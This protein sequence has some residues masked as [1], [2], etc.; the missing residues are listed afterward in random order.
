[1]NIVL[2]IFLFCGVFIYVLFI[3]NLLRKNKLELK[4]ALLWM[5]SGLFMIIVLVFPEFFLQLSSAIGIVEPVNMIFLLQGAFLLCLSAMYMYFTFRYCVRIKPQTTGTDS[6]SRPTG[7]TCPGSGKTN[8]GR[9]M[10]ALQR[11]CGR[12]CHPLH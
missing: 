11:S 6:R 8:A 4:Y 1:M 2:R 10:K 7:K 3:I 5:L 9:K 12:F